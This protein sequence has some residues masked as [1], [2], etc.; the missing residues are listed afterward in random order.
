MRHGAMMAICLFV[1]CGTSQPPDEVELVHEA[2]SDQGA[3]SVL[4]VDPRLNALIPADVRIEKLADGFTFTEGPVWRRSDSRLF[5]SDVR[6]NTLYQWTE[7]EGV[8]PF[9]QPVFEGDMTGRGSV[10]SNGLTLDSKGRLVVCEHGYRQVSRIEVDGSRTVLVDNFEG[11]R[12]NSPND[13]VYSSTGWLYFTDPPYGLADAEES[14]LRELNF[15]GIYRLS[16][17]GELELLYSEQTR[18][19]GIALSPDET[20]LYVANSDANRKVW[21]AYDIG[22]DGVSNPRVFYDVTP[23]KAEGVP[24]GLKVDRAGNLF[25]T[26]P[27]G[28]WVITPDGTHLGTIQPDE[29]PAN[30]GWGDDGRTLYM[31]A[32]T[33]LYRIKLTTEGAIPWP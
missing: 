26:G 16:P 14:P 2:I 30:V 23:E 27:G 3:G 22:K 1:A 12:L 11:G 13:A 19:N 7:S 28:V 21:M 20:I 33:G 31:T 9:L 17:D 5:F 15:S 24:D 25:A 6:D 32:R 4:R 8:T 18:P 10:S 29:I